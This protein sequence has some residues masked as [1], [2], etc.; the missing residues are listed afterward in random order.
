MNLQEQI[1]RIHE[2]MDGNNRNNSSVIERLLNMMFV[3]KHDIVCKVEV[4]HPDER[5]V[6]DGQPKYKSYSLT[7]TFIGGP[8]TE[9]WPAPLLL[10]DKYE[11]LMNEAWMIVYDYTNTPCDIYSKYVKECPDE[12]NN[13]SHTE[14]TERC[15]KGY[16]QKG[17][18][19]MFGKRYPNCVK[20][21]KK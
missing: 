17:M 19:T 2:M 6:L 12:T 3:D 18:K 14:L 7:V 4:K 21:T 5:E 8:D 10:R 11:E 1:S 20:K 15:W 9:Y 13:I 16:T